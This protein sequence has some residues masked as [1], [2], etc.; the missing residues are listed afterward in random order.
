MDFVIITSQVF[1][2]LTVPRMIFNGLTSWLSSRWDSSDTSTAFYNGDC[3]NGDSFNC[4][5]SVDLSQIKSTKR[6]LKCSFKEILTC[7]VGSALRQYMVDSGV[8]VPQN[9]SAML[10]IHWPHAPHPGNLRIDG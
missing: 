5:D 10:N 3:N 2:L 9:L 8:K 6:K 1:H 4:W 7:A